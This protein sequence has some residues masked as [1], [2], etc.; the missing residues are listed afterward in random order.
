MNAER[1][2]IA[3]EVH[4]RP[5]AG[6][7][8]RASKYAERARSCSTGRSGR[9]RAIQFPI[10]RAYAEWQAADLVLRQAAAL[11]DAGQPAGE[12]ANIGEAA[13]L[14]S[15]LA[16]GGGLHADPRR[17]RRGA[18]IRHRAQVARD[19]AS[20]QIAPISTNLILAY[21]G[22][23]CS[24]CR[25]VIEHRD[26]ILR[27]E[28]LQVRGP[29]VWPSFETFSPCETKLLRTRAV[30]GANQT[31]VPRLAIWYICS[32]PLRGCP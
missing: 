7:S 2:L 6:S 3:A 31:R 30:P 10:A 19:A 29:S 25:G 15:G 16:R 24:A 11:F 4:R 18:R 27:N 26:L 1:I 32:S 20:D 12:E 22:S 23:T 13:G 17:L 28:A 8:R 9:T 14:R 21:L 5:R